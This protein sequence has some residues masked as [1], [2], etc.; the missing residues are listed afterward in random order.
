MTQHVTRQER[1]LADGR[2]LQCVSDGVATVTINNPEKH[3]AMSLDMWHALGE[4]VDIS[5]ADHT[6]RVIL[7]SSGAFAEKRKPVFHGR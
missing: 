4:A 2:I 5:V 7:G 6:V 1:S 3:N